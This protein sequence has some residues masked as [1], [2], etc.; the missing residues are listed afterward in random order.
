VCS[1]S[2]ILLKLILKFFILLV[3]FLNYK[4]LYFY[5]SIFFGF[6]VLIIYF[7]MHFIS[8]SYGFCLYSM[9]TNKN[10]FFNC[11][12]N[13]F[14]FFLTF[15][16]YDYF[17]VFLFFFI[18]IYYSIFFILMYFFM[19]IDYKRKNALAVFYSSFVSGFQFFFCY[20]SFCFF[21]SLIY[22]ELSI[23]YSFLIICESI[24]LT[25]S[26]IISLLLSIA[27]YTLVERK[28]MASIQRRCGPNI[29]GFLGILQPFSDGLKLIL[30]EIIIPI[31]SNFY[32]FLYSPIYMF[33]VSL[34]LWV[35]IPWSSEII[36]FDYSY[37]LLYIIA[38]SS[39]NIFGLIIA[40]WSSNSKYAFLGSI[41]SSAQMISYEIGLSFIYIFFIMITASFDL[42]SI[43]LFQ[44]S[45]KIWFIVPFFP[46][47]LIFFCA[48]LAETNRAPFD[49][50]EAEAELVSGYNTEYS[51]IIFALFFLAEYSNMLFMSCLFSILFLGGWYNNIYVSDSYYFFIIKILIVAFMFIWVRA[52]LPRYRYDQLMSIGWEFFLPVLFGFFFLFLFYFF[53]SHFFIYNMFL[54][55]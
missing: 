12:F 46:L 3:N 29:V 5:K 28:I 1:S 51:S 6:F 49:L 16:N 14:F 7:I 10:F 47:A 52:S 33:I 54:K 35:V 26:I 43:V 27:L 21:I 48:M 50:P 24:F 9:I 53:S 39:L 40:G 45:L 44:F 30:K 25:L 20:D 15:F 31:Y 19:L 38:I 55:V 4:F 34:L 23:F 41:R 37:S 11:Y 2:S 13:C 8:L 22:D 17:Y 32:L 42:Y 18:M 36:F